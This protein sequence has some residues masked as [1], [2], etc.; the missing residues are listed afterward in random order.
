[1]KEI[2]IIRFGTVT[3]YIFAVHLIAYGNLH[4]TILFLFV[5]GSAFLVVV[6]INGHRKMEKKNKNDEN[7]M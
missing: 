1:M 5:F 6:Q 3:L 4:E 7:E 2:Y